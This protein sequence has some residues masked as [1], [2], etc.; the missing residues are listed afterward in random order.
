MG[1][2]IADNHARKAY[3]EGH[4]EMCRDG[5]QRNLIEM[6]RWLCR[7]KDERIVEHG[8]WTAWVT[9]Y[10]GVNERTAQRLMRVAR[11]I[12]EGSTLEALGPA[13]LEELIKLPA[14]E[15]ETAA[16]QMD[17]AGKSSR[18][19]RDEVAAI[20]AERDEALRLVKAQKDRAE[21]EKQD[22]VREAVEKLARVKAREMDRNAD[23]W[24]EKVRAGKAREEEL[25]GKIR[26]LEA[27]AK[28]PTDDDLLE[29]VE[30]LRRQKEAAEAE[31]DRLAD[32][33]DRLK[34]ENAQKEMDGGG[35]VSARILSAMGGMMVQVGTIPAQLTTGRITIKKADG[36]L[37]VGKVLAVSAWCRAMLEALGVE[38]GA[39]S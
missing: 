11:E 14:P 4:L 28:A 19:V 25:L 27:S 17:A 18:Q 29:T 34:M 15:R 9:R 10:A 39:A 7:A 30:A 1:N 26:E 31:T 22:A 2:I 36:S 23:I 6:G 35:D 21:A 16:Q 38:E 3:I 32:E 5:A 13:K 20:R 24:A 37:I 33:L 12:P 8:E